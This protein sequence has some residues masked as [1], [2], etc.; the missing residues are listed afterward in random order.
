MAWRTALFA[1]QV[2][3]IPVT[4]QLSKAKSHPAYFTLTRNYVGQATVSRDSSLYKK[5]ER[6]ATNY[7]RKVINPRGIGRIGTGVAST[8]APEARGK[9]KALSDHLPED[10][11]VEDANYAISNLDIEHG[12]ESNCISALSFAPNG[13]VWIGYQTGGISCLRGQEIYHIGERQGIENAE[14]TSIVPY[15]GAVWVGTFGSG[16]YRVANGNIERFSKKKGFPT[17]HILDMDIYDGA[18]WV[19]TYNAGMVR[20]DGKGY[21]HFATQ[22]TVPPRVFALSVDSINQLLYY[23]DYEGAVYRMGKNGTVSR[24]DLLP[25]SPVQDEITGISLDHGVLHVLF[26]SGHHARIEGETA[27]VYE[28]VVPGRYTSLFTSKAGSTWIGSDGGGLWR[29]EGDIL[30]GITHAEGLSKSNIQALGEDQAG[31]LWLGSAR[32]GIFIL[33][34]TPFRTILHE[35]S[36]LHTEINATCI[37]PDGI[38]IP[39]SKGLSLMDDEKMLTHYSHR[40]LRNLTGIA[41]RGD[42]IWLTNYAGLIEVAHDSIFLHHETDPACTSFNTHRGLALSADGSI[43]RISNYNHGYLQYV[44]E[45]RLFSVLDKYEDFSLT[46]FTFEDSQGRIWIGSPTAGL[47]YLQGAVR[48]TLTKDFGE[49][50]AYTEDKAGSIWV[51]TSFG[52][53]QY[54]RD[55]QL[56][57]HE[58]VGTKSN[59]EVRALLYLSHDNTL[60]IGTAK[61]LLQYEHAR[62][63]LRYYTRAQ[64]ISGTY[65][66]PHTVVSNPVSSFWANNK[67]LLQHDWGSWA[68]AR[69]VPTLRLVSI[70][71]SAYEPKT[72]WIA[73]AAQEKAEFDSL[74]WG[75]PVNLRL[76]DEVRQLEFHLSTGSWF[77]AENMTLYYRIG[78]VGEWIPSTWTNSVVLFGLKPMRYDIAFKVVSADGIES[79]PVHYIFS[80]RKPF[81]LELWF[82]LVVAIS[83]GLLG[84]YVLKQAFRIRFENARSY[85]DQDAYLKRVRLLGA[86]MAIGLPL[87]ELTETKLDIPGYTYAGYAWMAICLLIGI[88]LWM[89]TFIRQIKL[90]LLR[91]IVLVVSIGMMLMMLIR[92]QQGDY[93]PTFT[94]GFIVVFSFAS[95]ILDNIQGFLRFATAVGMMLAY[96]FVWID[97]NNQNHLLFLT[98]IPFAFLFGG[99]YHVLQLYKISNLLFGDKILSV[100][101]K[102]VLVCDPE[103]RIVYCNDYVLNQLNL[104]EEYLLGEGWW[105]ISGVKKNDQEAIRTAIRA[106]LNGDTEVEVFASRLIKPSR[107]TACIL[108]WEYQAIE[109]GYLMG[110][111]SDITERVEQEAMI[112]TLSLIAAT[113]ENMVVITDVD[114]KIEWVNASFCKTTGY[115]F[116][117]VL[118]RNPDDLLQGPQTDASSTQAIRDALK[119]GKT[120]RG[121]LVNYGKNGHPFWVMIDI[122]PILDE[123]DLVHKFVSLSIDITEKKQRENEMLRALEEGEQKYRLIADNTS[124]GIAILNAEGRFSFTSPSFINILRYPPEMYI[125]ADQ[126]FIL[127]LV[128]PDDRDIPIRQYR[129]ALVAKREHALYSYRIRHAEGHYV[130]EED[131][132][133][134][135]YDASGK[136]Q[137]SYLIAR[138]ISQ[139]IQKEEEREQ[140]LKELTYSFEELQQFSFITQHNLRAPVANFLGLI[141]MIEAE[142]IDHPILPKFIAAMR[143]TA[144][145]FD[146]TIR[147]LHTVLS[148]KNRSEV[149]FMPLSLAGA[150]QQVLEVHAE[151]ILAIGPAI[152]SDFQAAMV[153][154]NA[155][156]LHS[157]F[158][159][160]ITNA[161]K[162][163]DAGR[164]LAIQV[165]SRLEG[166]MVRVTFSDNGI[167][168]DVDKYQDRI[169]GLYQRFHGDRDGKG[170]G[171]YL[172]K[173]QVESAGGRVMAEGSPDVGFT[174][175]MWL[176]RVEA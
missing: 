8:F 126:H 28:P 168:L 138:D 81:Y 44:P 154:F 31:N 88:A 134:F 86:I 72:D 30:K 151:E 75:L 26:N 33:A 14:V 166:G 99:V 23:T 36:P 136:H 128:H 152:T 29:A 56:Y 116:E 22:Q 67:G 24:L 164:P 104:P 106:R 93:A 158:S 143:V 52:L 153:R 76:S 55:K 59:N 18:L 157:I 61:G 50:Y 15:G 85:S 65:F 91:Q 96:T 74:A 25:L 173:S 2:R 5:F 139:R 43:L 141:G 95:V 100:Y 159:N 21:H 57:H 68:N 19:G 78:N 62:G 63:R 118:G 42:R 34:E 131:S 114:R 92:T 98:N 132:V 71:L 133:T 41:V 172:L 54:T 110:I 10:M 107:K 89:S 70:D 53:L 108:E 135:I 115:A 175:H 90:D 102:Y 146:Q 148:V 12:L 121:E 127:E 66:T 58:F 37:H 9:F 160:L 137:K 16:L 103:G 169:F 20:I 82:M 97:T 117:E 165:R 47:T 170:F 174:V 101:D 161:L 149:T 112:K 147:D 49:V 48:T 162:F 1:Q 140:L 51:G 35:E 83:G 119:N 17:D 46:N 64:G 124:D 167:G 163:K 7:T 113:T 123:H 79:Q 38:L 155:Q 111:G 3:V 32:H 145:G 84:Y 122:Q 109:S 77:A 125:K 105:S 87:S 150:L 60:W 142:Q 176:P 144:E 130:W 80:V 120:F 94:I 40:L 11:R 156:Y 27:W 39:T 69:R 171:L 13:E 4:Q 129:E 6:V 73:I 45:T